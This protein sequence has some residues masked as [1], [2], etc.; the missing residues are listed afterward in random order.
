MVN[1]AGKM[2][3]IEPPR[4]KTNNL[5]RRKQRRRFAV[6]A[7]LISAFVFAS[8]IVH[9]LFFFNFKLLALFCD[10]TGRFVSDLVGNHIVGL[11]T[12][13]LNYIFYGHRQKNPLPQHLRSI[14]VCSLCGITSH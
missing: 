6:T 11:P 14:I 10:C 7:K 9:F 5:H 4:E 13:R 1:D 8:R 12:R 2:Q 3:V